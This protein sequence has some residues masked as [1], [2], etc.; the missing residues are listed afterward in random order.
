MSL[1]SNF[2]YCVQLG[3]AKVKEIF[4]LAFKTEERYP[5]NVGPLTRNFSGRQV[6]IN[7]RVHDDNDRAADLS[8]LDS[9]HILFSFP[10][11]LSAETAD[12]PDPSL[13]RITMQARV[14]VPAKM[15]TWEEEGEEVLGLSF[16]DI[17][18]TDVTITELAGLPSINIDNFLAAIHSRYML[19]QHVYTYS[20]NRLI[21]YDGNRDM[22]LDPPNNATPFDITAVL[23]NSGSDE[24]L[25]ITAPINVHVPLMGFGTYDSYGRV[26]F[27][28]RVERTDTTVSVIMGTEPSGAGL[29]TVV[30]LDNAHPARSLVIT[31]LTPLIISALNGYG[32][33]TEPAISES[34]AR[35]M[36]QEEIA[37]YLRERRYPVYTP[38]S[39]DPA[40]P[41]STPVGMLLVADGIMAIL[42]NERTPADPIAVPDNFLGSRDL[43]LA[44]GRAKVNELIAEAV[45]AEFPGLSSGGHEVST[46]EGS[47][48][49][50]SLSVEPSDAGTHDQS[51]GHLWVTGDAEVHID[52]W[53]DPDVSFA[54]P[55]FVDATSLDT[56]DGC[57]LNLSPRAGDFDFDQSC[58]D[59]FLDIIIPIVGWIMLA[60]IES[61]IDEVGGELAEEIA[62]AQGRL[63]EPV[64]PV[65]NGIAEVTAC[66][67][68]LTI[69]SGGFILR[70]TM[71]VRRLGTSYEDLE[72]EGDLPRP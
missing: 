48:T 4:H 43:A 27:H 72:G 59:V 37:A 9:R 28:R 56:P 26:I 45:A 61:T 38:R 18:A 25:R 23:V 66:L 6:I 40:E 19:I 51:V 39:P 24:Y 60:I 12:A 64:P 3:I 44:V 41:L 16:F 52:C 13:S 32:T 53:P 31:N 62:G 67:T 35:Q 20:G 14:D 70:G 30:E 7:V 42:L 68:G 54:G 46:E 15:D 50:Q 22:T 10:F 21:L 58:C 17:Q 33:I 55:I 65:V 49:L 11:D 47:A 2:D 69:T 57:E 34:A 29:S 5:H 36:L 63:I 71:T 1:T 8:F